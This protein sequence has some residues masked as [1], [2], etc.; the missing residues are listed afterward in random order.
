MRP[1]PTI[2]WN[3]VSTS[4]T[5]S[6]PAWFMREWTPRRCRLAQPSPS[7]NPAAQARSWLSNHEI[8]TET[9]V[10]VCPLNVQ[11]R[12]QNVRTLSHK[13]ARLV[14]D[15]LAAREPCLDVVP[16]ADTIAFAELPAKQDLASA[17][18]RAEVDE[19]LVG[20]LHVH[21]ETRDLQEK[22]VDLSRDRVRRPPVV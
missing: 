12:R 18:H 10:R 14:F 19:A 16:V 1:T 3:S 20:V 13:C 15:E 11:T 17:A 7:K 6:R 5:P 21:A 9:R 22:R 2:R 4:G 8:Q